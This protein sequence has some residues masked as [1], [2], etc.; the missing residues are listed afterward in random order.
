VRP[1]ASDAYVAASGRLL[2]GKAVRIEVARRSAAGDA[3]REVAG[4]ALVGRLC[5]AWLCGMRFAD[6][7]L[8]TGWHL[9][10]P[11][12][13]RRRPAAQPLLSALRNRRS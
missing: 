5:A 11:Q 9:L 13:L 3:G 6:Q 8:A 1:D 4:T 2:R 12:L 7:D 10:D